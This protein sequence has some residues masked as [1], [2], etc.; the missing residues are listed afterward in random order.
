MNAMDGR[1]GYFKLNLNSDL[2]KV[3]FWVLLCT[4]MNSNYDKLRGS[5]GF[6]V[7]YEL[8]KLIT[9]HLHSVAWLCCV[10]PAALIARFVQTR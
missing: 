7:D 5:M 6:D 10:R 1:Q 4:N 9:S 8:G 2:T 3:L